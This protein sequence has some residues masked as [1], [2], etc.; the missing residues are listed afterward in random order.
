MGRDFVLDEIRAASQTAYG[1]DHQFASISDYHD[2]VTRVSL[3]E[4]D[5]IAAYIQRSLA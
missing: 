3:V 2:F 4:Y 5:D 1:I